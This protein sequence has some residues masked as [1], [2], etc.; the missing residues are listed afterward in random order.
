M[1]PRNPWKSLIGVGLMF[2]LLEG[3]GPG[4]TL[5]GSISEDLSLEFESVRV[6]VQSDAVRVE[7]IRTIGDV[8]FKVCKLSID[9]GVLAPGSNFIADADFAAHVN[10]TRVVDD[11]TR[12]PDVQAGLLQLFDLDLAFGDE[13][14]GNFAVEFVTGQSLR[15]D[16]SAEP[17]LIAD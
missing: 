11:D 9:R 4:N 14:R 3:C 10:L 13:V 17:I 2:L 5:E 8:L 7:Y 16:F 6:V 15:G 1:S 12:F